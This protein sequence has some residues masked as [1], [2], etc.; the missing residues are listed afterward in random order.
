[1]GARTGKQFLEGLRDG[2]EIWVDGELVGDVTAHPSLSGAANT[3]AELFD[4]QHEHADICLTP[5]DETGEP[6][7]VT[8]VI[9]RSRDDLL[10][11]R[12]AIEKVSEYTVGLMGRSPDYLNVT[13]AGFAGSP[14][15]WSLGGNEAGAH[16]LIEFQKEL[17]RKDLSLTHTIIHATNDKSIRDAPLPDDPYA[18]RK[19]G[20]NARGIVVRGSKIL[21]TLAPFSDEIAVYPAAPLGEDREHFALSF[22]IPIST[23]G[24]RVLCRDSYSNPSD[25]FRHPL[26]SRFD[27]Q[28]AFIIFDSVEVPW[29]RVFIDGSLEAYNAVP[30]H[31]WFPNLSHQSMIRAQTKL[32]FAHALATRMAE[33]VNDRNPAT[34]QLLGEIAVYAELSRSAIRNAE[35]EAYDYG[36]GTWFP[37]GEPLAALRSM[38]PLWFPRV[39][40]IIRI[41]GSHNLLATPSEAELEDEVLG[42]LVEHF[43]GGAEHIG[44]KER[45][46]TY[47]LAWDYAASSMGSRNEQY[48]RFYLGS[49]H[50]SMRSLQ[51][52]ADRD[53]G[54]RLVDQFLPD[55]DRSEA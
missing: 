9:P 14:G 6:I 26:S 36:E 27:E 3:L 34:Q 50:M 48:E 52:Q 11:R 49:S 7:N 30:R 46:A 42:P 33:M 35:N 44:A 28:D 15:E 47:R 39:N 54:N 17:R 19:V 23:P 5:D 12:A 18:V 55:I 29:D 13:F 8:H 45:I 10:R 41:I 31:G 32:E 25:R 51:G 24:L 4:L 53:R 16:R 38:L 22:S 40:E 2:R 43:L 20:E 37:A 21:A 1:M